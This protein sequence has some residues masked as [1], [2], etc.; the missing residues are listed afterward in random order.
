MIHLYYCLQSLSLKIKKQKQPFR[1]TN[2]KMVALKIF[3]KALKENLWRT[4]FV[5]AFC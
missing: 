5:V 1:K 4:S 3:R 2:K